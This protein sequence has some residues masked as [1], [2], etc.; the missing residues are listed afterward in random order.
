MK[1]FYITSLIFILLM[2]IFSPASKAHVV[3]NVGSETAGYIIKGTHLAKRTSDW[4]TYSLAIPSAYVDI[5]NEGAKRWRETGIYQ[6]SNKVA[7]SINT[8][9]TNNDPLSSAYAVTTSYY[10][11]DDYKIIQWHI[12]YN[13]YLMV[14]L[15]NA[16]KQAVA[17]HEI[18]HTLGL[19]D[20]YNTNNNTNIM[21]GYGGDALKASKPSN[22]DKVGAAIAVK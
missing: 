1:K 22:K 15:T 16:Q 18:G 2:T 12:K 6:I 14:K 9:N 7:K 8:I 11:T 20:L 19:K 3:G 17:T 5:T 4:T 21:Y 13:I 10:Y